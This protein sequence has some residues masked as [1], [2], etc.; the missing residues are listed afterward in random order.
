[1][2]LVLVSYSRIFRIEKKNIKYATYIGTPLTDPPRQ[3]AELRLTESPVS[4]PALVVLIFCLGRSQ[5]L[6]VNV[7][8]AKPDL[9]F[10]YSV[11]CL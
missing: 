8:P 11:R 9:I 3:S 1:M 7:V 4:E 6:V 10:N 2:Y 5:G